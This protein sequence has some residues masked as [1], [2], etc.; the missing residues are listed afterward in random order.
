MA[1]KEDDKKEV[2]LKFVSWIEDINEKMNIKSNIPQIKEQDISKIASLASKEAN[3]LYPVP[4]LYDKKELEKIIKQI[5]S[6]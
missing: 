2:F 3:P 5:K 1:K 4:K 6:N